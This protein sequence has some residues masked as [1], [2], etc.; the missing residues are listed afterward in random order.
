VVVAHRSPVLD[1]MLAIKARPQ[2]ASKY[3]ELIIPGIRHQIMRQ[4][5]CFMYTDAIPDFQLLSFDTL[6]ELWEASHTLMIEQLMRKC[7]DI[8]KI[9]HN[10]SISPETDFVSPPT[11]TDDINKSS[12]CSDMNIAL[13]EGRFS[14]VCIIAEEKTILAHQC[15]LSAASDYFAKVLNNAREKKREAKIILELP[16][17]FSSVMRLL[18]FLYTGHLPSS[19]H[20][21]DLIMDLENAHRYKLVELKSLCDSRIHVTD[22]NACD[23][24][25]LAHHV[26]SPRLRI[27]S[28]HM[29]VKTLSK[30]FHD[31]SRMKRFKS[32]LSQCP[33]GTKDEL[34]ELIKQKNGLGCILPPDRKLLAADLHKRYLLQ[35]SRLE[36][37]MTNELTGKNAKGLS[38][39]S[40]IIL[41][42][43]AIGYGYLQQFMP[44]TGLVPIINC[45]VLVATCIHFFRRL[46]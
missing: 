17:S 36:T 23:M 35:K 32:I 7:K 45:M 25:L 8:L 13:Q 20:E 9:D 33:M 1:Q 40:T 44:M 41:L 28:M 39:K 6:V 12:F 15:I 37:Q 29:I 42:I 31:G 34:F 21:H 4:V 5:L 14:D 43:L 18:G 16:G 24:L 3:I 22:A 10:Y 2:D 46:I 26:Q 27:R 38:T 19:N 11:N 30:Q